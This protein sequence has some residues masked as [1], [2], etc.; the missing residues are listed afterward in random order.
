GPLAADDI[1]AFVAALQRIDASDAPEPAY[2]RGRPLAERDEG[3][4][5]ALERVDA[6]GALELWEEAMLAPEWEGERVWIHADIDARNVLVRDG[7]FAAVL[8]WGGSG[9]GDPALDAMVAWKLIA[10]EERDRF[11]ELLR[12][13][14][15]TW[16]RAQGWV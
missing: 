10:R 14:D 4:R 16:L 12:V 13:D 1:A 2:G 8:D 5:D 15:A 11:R 7:R 3:V 9:A 6:P